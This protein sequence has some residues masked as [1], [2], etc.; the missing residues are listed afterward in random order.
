[1]QIIS[2]LVRAR[3]ARAEQLYTDEAIADRIASEPIPARLLR[4]LGVSEAEPEPE[5]TF[6]PSRHDIHNALFVV[7]SIIGYLIAITIWII[8][9]A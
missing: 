4:D 3:Q 2:P 8:K 1:M 6:M 7:I 9:G 5:E